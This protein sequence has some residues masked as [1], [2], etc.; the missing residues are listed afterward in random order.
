MSYS[1]A[2]R[3]IHKL[4]VT[5]NT[6]YYTRSN[7]CVGVRDRESGQWLRRHLAMSKSL[8]GSIKFSRGGL[9]PN[10]G[11]PEVGESL[12]FHGDDVDVVTSTVVSVARPSKGVAA[13]LV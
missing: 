7:V 3:R 11:N 4:Y 5:R 12:F 13:Q 1:G 2:E 8:C 9:H 6:E 10:T